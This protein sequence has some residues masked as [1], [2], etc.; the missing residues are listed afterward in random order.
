M[1]LV[2]KFGNLR[3]LIK[4]NGGLIGSLK[5][6]I[7]TDDIREMHFVGEDKFGNKYYQN[8][9][10]FIGRNRIV[11]YNVEVVGFDKDASQIPA[12]WHGWMH[13]VTDN[14]PTKVPPKPRKWF[15]EHTENMTGTSDDYVPYS[16][17]RPK[18][19]SWTPPRA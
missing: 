5:S 1:S 3:R 7:W 2:S 13:Y 15:A 6:S 8:D 16:T 14:P 11:H 12:E 10:Y 9:N 18:I 19:E 4:S 17:A